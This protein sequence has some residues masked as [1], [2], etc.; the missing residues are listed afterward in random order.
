MELLE[1]AEKYAVSSGDSLSMALC[2]RVK[3]Q[4][5]VKMKRIEDAIEI[6]EFAVPITERNGFDRYDVALQCFLQAK[7]LAA[8]QNDDRQY[9][10]NLHNLGLLYYKLK[11][12]RKAIYSIGMRLRNMRNRREVWALEK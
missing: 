2:W 11:D 12:Y 3:G 6:F 9:G 10:S 1:R 5:F 7:D 4:L 8:A